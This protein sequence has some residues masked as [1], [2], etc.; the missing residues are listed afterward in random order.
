M[1]IFR[2][3][4][5]LMSMD[6][7][8][9]ERHANPLSAWTR[10]TCGPLIVLAIWSRDW[11]GWWS[12]LP[13]AV[14]L[15]WTWLNPRIFGPP[16]STDNWASKGTFGERIFLKRAERPVPAHHERAAKLLTWV[17]ALGLLPLV[18]GLVVFDARSTVFGLVVAIGA[19]VWFVDRMVWLYEDMKDT[20][21]EY[22]G[23]LRR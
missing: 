7:A 1:D 8:A 15:F 2:F 5:R 11:L 4:E 14:A 20:S 21:P 6:E 3:A 10:F 23:W 16:I 18:Y 13:L 19:K 17:S 9:W 12:L 22:A